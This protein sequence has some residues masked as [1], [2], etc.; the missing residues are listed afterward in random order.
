MSAA[1]TNNKITLRRIFHPTDLSEL[2]AAAFAHALKLAIANKGL[3]T[4]MHANQHKENTTWDDFPMVRETLRGWGVLPESD[5]QGRDM[6]KIGI[7]VQKVIGAVHDPVES[8]I[9]YLA[10]HVEDLIVLTTH[11]RKGDFGLSRRAVAEPVA[12]THHASTLFVPVG[13]DGFVSADDGSIKLKNILIPVDS[14]PKAHKALAVVSEL[15]RSLGVKDAEF[16]LLSV[17]DKGMPLLHPE[18]QD[19]W[20][21]QKL[22]TDGSVVSSILTSAESI[23]ADLIVM[24]T[25]GHHGFLDAVRGSTTEI[26][27]RE[28][29][30]PL[31]AVTSS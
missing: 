4:I 2:S 21:W 7:E 26:V 14:K 23:K 12:R 25:A 29:T 1:K 6:H 20:N 17:G 16:T 30:C 5:I 15:V 28:T 11:Q 10:A 22:T 8:I 13:V 31:L 19:D 24:P 18:Q 27:L 3:L 9:E